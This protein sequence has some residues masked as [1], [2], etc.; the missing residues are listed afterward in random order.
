MRAWSMIAGIRLGTSFRRAC[1]G[2]PTFIRRA[3]VNKTKRFVQQKCSG[4]RGE[5]S[6]TDLDRRRAARY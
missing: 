6:S 4:D 2:R 5:N 3:P 1:V